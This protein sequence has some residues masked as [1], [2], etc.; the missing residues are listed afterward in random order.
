[1]KVTS[2]AI[3][4]LGVM[5]FLTQQA[6]AEQKLLIQQWDHED[7]GATG[8]TVRTGARF[9]TGSLIGSGTEMILIDQF[10]VIG[11][12]NAVPQSSDIAVFADPPTFT[13]GHI[14]AQYQDGVF[15]YLSHIDLGGAAAITLV[16]EVTLQDFGIRLF[17]NNNGLQLA[18]RDYVLQSSDLT[19]VPEPGSLLLMVSCLAGTAVWR[20]RSV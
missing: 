7:V 11:L 9:D 17:I 6:R 15:E 19:T 2:L 16:N 3:L 14:F 13:E 4:V 20:R 5:M 18:G 8:L 1:M 12:L 10:N